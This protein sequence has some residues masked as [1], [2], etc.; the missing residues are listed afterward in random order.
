M[1][2]YARREAVPIGQTSADR[3]IG[4]LDGLQAA[5]A[6]QNPLIEE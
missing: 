2:L 4:L 1:E 6:A 5:L 3:L